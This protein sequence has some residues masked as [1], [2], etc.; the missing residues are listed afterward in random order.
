MS[1]TIAIF[2]VTVTIT[3]GVSFWIGAVVGY[4]TGQRTAQRHLRTKIIAEVKPRHKL[5]QLEAMICRLNTISGPKGLD[6]P[7]PPRREARPVKL[8]LPEVLPP[9]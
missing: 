6:L 3:A 2:V 1:N 8:H 9:R 5:S 7:K 4:S